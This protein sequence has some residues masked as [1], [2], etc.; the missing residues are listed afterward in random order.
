MEIVNFLI[1]VLFYE[2][3]QVLSDNFPPDLL[4]DK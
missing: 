1:I 2:R 4:T 3:K